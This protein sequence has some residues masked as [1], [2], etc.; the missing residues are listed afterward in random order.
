MRRRVTEKVR[1][2]V[3][4]GVCQHV[5]V[6]E[7]EVGGMRHGCVKWFGGGVGCV[8]VGGG[9]GGAGAHSFGLVHHAP[10]GRDPSPPVRAA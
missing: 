10:E 4:G 6:H 7:A 9:G 1:E 3:R 5:G 8:T 2:G